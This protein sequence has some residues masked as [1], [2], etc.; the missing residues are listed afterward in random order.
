MAGRSDRRRGGRGRERRR[1]AARHG[2]I[3]RPSQRR[4]ADGAVHTRRGAVAMIYFCCDERRRQAL[5]GHPTLNGI[6]FLEV[7]DDPEAPV[8]DR[9]RTLLVNFIN[10]LALYS[11]NKTN[12]RIEGGERS[13]DLAIE[14]TSIGVADQERVL[15]VRVNHPGDFS[16]YTLRLVKSPNSAQ[17]PTGFDP[18]LSSIAFSFKV[19][20]PSD[21]DCRPEQV[22]PPESQT[23][24]LIDY[25]AKDYA[26]FRQL[27]L[28]R[29]AALAPDWRE[30]NP[31]DLGIALVELLAY[32]GDYLSYQQDAVAT[33]AYLGTA[34]R[35][36]SARR[37]ARLV[38]Y[39]MSDGGNG[40]AWVKVQVSAKTELKRRAQAGLNAYTT[41]LLTRAA[42]QPSRIAFDAFTEQQIRTLGVE[43]FEPLHDAT[44]FP[45]HNQMS[46]YTWGAL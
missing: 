20:C 34:R 3:P 9:Q 23:A 35:R 30:R 19:N 45:A 44:L 43:V 8:E 15:T 12:L 40:R 2:A 1:D 36:V 26:S 29:L 33:E 18:Q 13:S 42:G 6:D 4:A 21:F 41:K 14:T 16:I 7:A 11:L 22:C 32:A 46:F 38:D 24:P 17:P 25:L 39:A 5:L 28:D 37:H 27:M 10:P 31:A